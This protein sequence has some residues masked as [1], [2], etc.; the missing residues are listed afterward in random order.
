MQLQ[1]GN[2]QKI[3]AQIAETCKNMHHKI[4]IM[5]RIKIQAFFNLNKNYL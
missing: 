1:C 3:C 4:R 2:M 5:S